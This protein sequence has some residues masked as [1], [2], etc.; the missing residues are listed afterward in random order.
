MTA[1]TPIENRMEAFRQRWDGKVG[2]MLIGGEWREAASG[3]T[4]STEDPSTG[5]KLTD[6]ASAG[7][8]DVDAA[9]AAARGAFEGAWSKVKPD[10]RGRL[11]NKLADLIEARGEELALTETLD[12]GRPIQF[13]RM[14]DVGG[15]VGQLR[16][17]AGWASKIM[18]ETNEI[19]APGE[20]LSYVLR[21]P[22]GVVGQIVPW[23]FPLAM[24]CGKLGPA[25]AA[26]CTVVLKPAEQ[27]PLSTIILGE[28][29]LEAGFP[30]GVINIVTGYGRTAGAAL[31]S[32]MDVDKIAFTGSTV[33]GRAIIEASKSNFKRVSLELG[34]KSPT[35]IFA[36][37][38]LKKAIP[39]AAMGIFFNAGQVCAAGSR[40]FVAEEVADQVLEGI[41]GMA[42]M[43]RVG[44]TLDPETMI[45]PLVSEVQLD[46]VT[47]YIESGRQEGATVMIGGGRKDGPGWFVEPT[48]LVDTEASMKVRREEIFGPVLCVHR[49]SGEDDADRLA[50]MGNET[51]FGLSATIWTRDI[52]MAHRLARRLKAGTIRINGSGG[53]DPALPLGG[54]KASGWGRENGKAGVDA[55]TELKAVSVGLD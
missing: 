34:G 25:L 20:W 17:Q 19:S 31:A 23:N 1:Q 42:K 2:K 18:G 36:D 21:E 13:S 22:V 12:V 39:A 47:S 26:G 51:E 53:V 40:L 10:E 52:G 48:V 44:H 35:F 46:R 27:T 49:F 16:Y 32:H 3:E 4:F 14:V 5:E 28:L 33:T 9:V 37:A 43:L 55:Y 29:A 45:G 7:E 6:V 50:R 24:A 8:T 11:I 15:A 41:A 54:Y 38:D 30:E